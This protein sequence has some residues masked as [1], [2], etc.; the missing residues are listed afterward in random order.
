[1]WPDLI[2]V[3]EGIRVRRLN[4][5]C[6]RPRRAVLLSE[7]EK[8]IQQPP[9]PGATFDVMPNAADVA[10][11][12]PFK[13]LI[14]SPESTKITASSFHS[15]F[16]QLPEFISS[17]RAKIDC[18]FMDHI[19][20]PENHDNS[21]NQSGSGFLQLATSVFVVQSGNDHRLFMYPEVLLWPGF[22]CPPER[23]IGDMIDVSLPGV[24]L[25][26][27]LP[28]S[29]SRSFYPTTINLFDGTATVVR[30]S[31]L[32]PKTASRQDMNVLDARFACG[33]CS[34]P[35]RKVVMTWEMAVD[36]H[37]HKNC[38]Y[39]HVVTDCPQLSHA[40]SPAA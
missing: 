1:M 20:F 4:N 11:F 14:M 34:S 37:F 6:Y 5:Q 23:S 12:N 19:C 10:E 32:D 16:Q 8:Y 9:P 40:P 30:A 31:G 28:W 22:F 33:K 29:A 39:A 24:G 7:Y 3:L 18:E 38:D 2:T 17:W 36:D 15:A 25:F 26:G 21:E 13:D 35:G 27:C